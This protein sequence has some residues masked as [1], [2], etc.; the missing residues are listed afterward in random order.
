MRTKFQDRKRGVRTKLPGGT[1]FVGDKI[2]N[3]PLEDYEAGGA[4]AR[5]GMPLAG[6]SAR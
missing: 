2:T 1:T 5:A 4:T 6:G 3:L